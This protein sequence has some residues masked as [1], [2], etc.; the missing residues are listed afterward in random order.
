M[1]GSSRLAIVGAF[2]LG[3][4]LLFA[5]GIFMIGDRRLLFASS[6][7]VAA[8]FGN[9]T[10]VRIGTKVRVAGFDAG[11]VIDIAI[12]PSPSVR[13]RVIMRV[14]EDLHP[15][16]R[17][18]SV[19]AV[20]T[21]GLI[22]NAFIQI[23][24]GTDVAP[25]VADGGAIRGVDPVQIADLIEE[26]R[27]TF[28]TVAEEVLDLKDQ[29][30]GTVDSFEETLDTTTLLISDVGNDVRTIS[31]VSALFMDDARAVASTV[32]SIADD[33]QAG[34][35]TIGQLVTNTALYDRVTGIA[36]SAEETM[37][38]VRATAGRVEDSFTNLT[39]PE[40]PSQRLLSDIRD[41]LDHTRDAMS[42]LAENTEALKR[43]WLFR[44]FFSDRGFF[45]LDS[46]SL[47]E[48]RQLGARNGQYA[49]LRIWLDA[50]VLFAATDDGEPAL[51][52]EGR[53]RLN[54]AMAQLLQYPRD[55]PLVVE[56]YSTAAAADERFLE[57]LARARLAREHL[58]DRFSRSSNLTGAMPMGDLAP[59]S[60]RGDG[61]WN[62]IA[63][64]LFVRP[65]ALRR[66]DAG[67]EP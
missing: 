64:T 55:S 47:D 46:M 58:V 1:I 50:E 18:D 14:T 39:D 67:A 41:V 62:G 5:V 44:G 52:P 49:P 43:N 13:F 6:F 19:A 28:R 27:N 66:T 7:E 51:T 53:S 38:S 16:V 63:V 32:R 11:E 30:S 3:G 42:D 26:G 8:D 2:V 9:V 17:A 36:T 10:G 40:G 35:G 57:G 61:R 37:K 12:P 29:I 65:E 23:R 48:Y 45:N 56:G 21:D 31:S 15:L 20:L 24:E 33:V 25:P 22:G 4:V 60:P 34:R 54:S 59:A